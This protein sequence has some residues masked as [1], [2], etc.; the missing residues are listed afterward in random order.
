MDWT[1]SLTVMAPR[2]NDPGS[3]ALILDG[4]DADTKRL[5]VVLR[6]HGAPDALT[7]A[8]EIDRQLR[9]P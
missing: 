4:V 3:H 9:E 1:V 2:R 6:E 5:L 7:L 8:D